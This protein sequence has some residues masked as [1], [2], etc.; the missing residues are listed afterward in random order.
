MN[1][2]SAY[3]CIA[4]LGRVTRVYLSHLSSIYVLVKST[5]YWVFVAPF[6]KDKKRFKT[7]HVAFQCVFVGNQSISIVFLVSLFIGMIMAMQIAYLLRKF[8][9]VMYVGS[10]VGVSVCREL[11]PLMTAIV[12][13]GRAGAAITAELGTM[14]VSEEIDALE[15]MGINPIRFLVVP[16]ILALLI[17]VPCLTIFA[18]LVGIYGGYLIGHYS[19]NIPTGLY[20]NK[21]IDA[22]A[23]KDIWT[24]MLKS[25]VFALVIGFIGCYEGLCVEGGAEGVG[26]A[27]TRSVVA[28]ITMIIFTDCILTS[29]FYFVFD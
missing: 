18:D 14:K 4:G 21:T 12:I 11:G 23:M 22:L 10:L 19:V 13:A 17:M 6:Q 7:E 5:C 28:A 24:G 16:R 2:Q 9:V 15:V 8:G 3:S 25:V 1:I 26:K 29:L 20:M 27:T